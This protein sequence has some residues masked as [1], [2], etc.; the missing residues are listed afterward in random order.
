MDKKLR[1]IAIFIIA[2]LIPTAIA[3]AFYATLSGELRDSKT[4]AL[5]TH[6]ADVEV[7]NCNTFSTIV[8]TTVGVSGQ[9]TVDV[10][11]VGA[12]T[13]LC[14]NVSFHDGGTGIPGDAAKG[15]YVDRLANGGNLNTGVYFTG[16]GPTAITLK[17]LDARSED[18]SPALWIGSLLIMGITLGIIALRRRR[19]GASA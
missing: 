9:F 11:S 4:N 2:L 18:S 5:W 7:F 19:F 14:I 1:L 3:A 12:T 8:T 17:S 15:P 16:T 10:S 13:G 6:G